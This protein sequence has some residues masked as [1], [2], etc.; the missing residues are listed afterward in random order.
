M[1]C[2]HAGDAASGC[3]MRKDICVSRMSDGA[4]R[5]LATDQRPGWFLA[6]CRS[7]AGNGIMPGGRDCRCLRQPVAFTG[8]VD[9]NSNPCR[10]VGGYGA[11]QCTNGA[12]DQ[13]AQ[14]QSCGQI[15]EPHAKHTTHAG[16]IIAHCGEE[17][18]EESVVDV[19]V[20]F[21]PRAD[22]HSG[23]PASKRAALTPLTC[24]GSP[25]DQR[26]G[27]W[28]CADQRPRSERPG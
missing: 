28:I 8:P 21:E 9:R 16:R 12:R 7:F 25:V 19:Q 24:G 4:E 11:R 18:A 23:V 3:A 10:I 1:R 15:L 26:V 27:E 2:H 14:E 17:R 5:C 20:S 22:I 6:G 13:A